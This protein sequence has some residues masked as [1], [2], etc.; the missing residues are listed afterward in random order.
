MRCNQW[1]ANIASG[2][3]AENH[4]RHHLRTGLHQAYRNF[5][6]KR[7]DEFPDRSGV[8]WALIHDTR[9]TAIPFCDTVLRYRSAI[10]F[11]RRLGPHSR[12]QV[13]GDTVLRYRSAIPFWRRLG[14][15]SRHQVDGDTVL[16]YRSAI[17][18][19]RRLGPHSRHQVD[20]DTVLRYRSG[21]DWALIHDTRSTAIPA[22]MKPMA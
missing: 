5:Q 12:H 15:H 9:S 20:S 22:T 3:I 18:F 21:V 7:A 11:W 4:H 16:R 6:A 1:I 2:A 8:D 10:P 14:P 17:P 19:W 13:D